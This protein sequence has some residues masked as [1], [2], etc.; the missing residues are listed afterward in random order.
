MRFEMVEERAR[1]GWL[2]LAFTAVWVVCF[3]VGLGSLMERSD[4]ARSIVLAGAVLYL[5]MAWRLRR[6]WL[7]RQ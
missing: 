2:L 7:S 4:L 6:W 3:T 5:P 1:F